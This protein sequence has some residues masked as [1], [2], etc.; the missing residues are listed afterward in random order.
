MLLLCAIIIV[1]VNINTIYIVFLIVTS[2]VLVRKTR[3][4][5]S[6]KFK[7][8]FWAFTASVI[9][10]TCATITGSEKLINILPLE[11]YTLLYTIS[12]LSSVV[13]NIFLFHFGISIL[14]YKTKTIIDYKIFPIVLYLGYM[15]LY[16]SGVIGFSELNITSRFSFGYNG[17]MLGC[18]G[19]IN[20]YYDKKKEEGSDTV[21]YG[22]LLLGT[23]LLAYAITE[24]LVTS[25]TIHEY[26]INILQIIYA[27]I[28]AVSAVTVTDLMKEDEKMKRIGFV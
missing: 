10:K 20:L 7:N 25:K 9:M 4:A 14:T 11:Q 27:V 28:L 16:V 22:L 18:V 6:S 8:I 19:C 3:I 1:M 13:S 23:G 12:I 15:M 5:Q 2:I 17:A 26:T 24:S 21:T